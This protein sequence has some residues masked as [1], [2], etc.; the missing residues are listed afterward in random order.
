MRRKLRFF[1]NLGRRA[2]T[3]SAKTVVAAVLL[4]DVAAGQTLKRVSPTLE[5]PW[6]MSFVDA[7]QVLVTERPGGVRL[8]DL[9]DASAV[10]LDGVPDVVVGGQGGMLDVLYDQ[11][12]VFLCYTG[13][14]SNGMSTT[15]LGK[16][17]LDGSALRR[18][19]VLFQ[20]SNAS[21]GLHHFGCRIGLDPSD[22]VYLSIG[23]RLDADSAQD[24][25]THLGSVVR[26]NRDGS[27]PLDNPF[28][29][30]AE[31]LPEIYSLGHRNPQGMSVH[32]DT[33]AV[34]INEHGPQGGDEINIVAAG[35]NYGWVLLVLAVVLDSLVSAI[36]FYRPDNI[37]FSYIAAAIEMDRF[38]PLLL[39]NEVL[40]SVLAILAALLV[41]VTC[42]PLPIWLNLI[43]QRGD[44]ASNHER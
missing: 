25:N 12:D 29:G 13:K 33:G 19:E 18:F 11:G 21:Y 27:V 43:D 22:H 42:Q 35:E 23:D 28:V 8:V 17:R 15:T 34:W 16:G 31:G 24:P 26:L 14:A 39:A 38:S 30:Q 5:N 6:G 41:L 36:S 4:A 44:N 1:I 7:Q 10:A 2:Q 20:A 32:P 9:S 3:L 37:F 40:A